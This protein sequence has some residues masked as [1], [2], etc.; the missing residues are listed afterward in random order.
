MNNALPIHS[1]ADLLEEEQRLTLLS[2]W[3]RDQLRE[4]VQDF[5]RQLA[6][7]AKVASFVSRVS[8]PARKNSLLGAGIGL[9]AGLLAEKAIGSLRPVRWLAGVAAPFLLKKAAGLLRRSKS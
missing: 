3:Q 6:P 4:D 8:A 2:A 9:G 7:V 1:Y 5:K